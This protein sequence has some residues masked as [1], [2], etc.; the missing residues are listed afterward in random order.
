MSTLS[1][2]TIRVRQS[3][4]DAGVKVDI[5]LELLDELVTWRASS[6]FVGDDD[7]VLPTRGGTRRD[8]HNS[9][10]LMLNV[11]ERAND[12][13]ANTAQRAPVG[14]VTVEARGAV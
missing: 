11:V 2:G 7:L 4:T 8:R 14:A 3:K 13:L 10:K 9:R 6:P 1:G 5:Q 12:R